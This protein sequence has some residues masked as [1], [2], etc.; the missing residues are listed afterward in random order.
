MSNDVYNNKQKSSL[1]EAY[2]KLREAQNIRNASVRNQQYDNVNGVALN[3]TPVSVNQQVQQQVQPQAQQQA[4]DASF[5][6]RLGGTVSQAA[7]NILR[8]FIKLGEGVVDA[9]IA[10]GGIFDKEWAEE[11]IKYDATD[12]IMTWAEE[13]ASA[14][15]LYKQKTGKSLYDQSW[16][17]DADEKV[18]DI[19][20]GIEQGIGNSLGF[21]ALSSIPYAGIGL[22]IMGAGGTSMEEAIN[23]PEY[24]GDYYKTWGYGAISGGIEYG[25]EKALGW[26]PS[27]GK[28]AVKSLKNALKDIGKNF[29][30]EGFEEVASEVINPLFKGMYNNKSL[31]ENYEDVTLENLATTFVIGGATGALMTGAG[32]VARTLYLSPE[33][34]K[35]ANEMQI[36]QEKLTNA[37]NEFKKNPNEAAATENFAKV[38]DEVGAKMQELGERIG[39]LADKYKNRLGS[40]Y[41]INGQK[42]KV[43]LSQELVNAEAKE[44]LSIDP[45][46][47]AVRETVDLINNAKIKGLENMNVE[48]V[49][50]SK[51]NGWIDRNTNTIYLN[52]N[53]QKAMKFILGHE[54]THPMENMTKDSAYRGVYDEIITSLK[55]NGTYDELFKTL[56]KRYSK[57]V[58]GKTKQQ[59]EE[60]INQ[61]IVAD[62]IG[63]NLTNFEEIQKLFTKQSTWEKFKDLIKN[64]RNKNTSS[65]AK[66]Y[67][68]RFLKAAA[69]TKIKEKKQLSKAIAYSLSNYDVEITLENPNKDSYIKAK[70]EF[71][72]T[73]RLDYAGW[74]NVDGS[75]LD[76]SDGQGYRVQD[77]REIQN[78]YKDSKWTDAL[79]QYLAE[80]NIRLQSYG[81]EVWRKPTSQQIEV[82]KR[83]IKNNYGE[84]VVDIDI[85]KNGDT[86][87]FEYER[88]TP[89][90][91]I[92]DD[93]I[94]YFDNGVEPKIDRQEEFRYS[95]AEEYS[96]QEDSEGEPLTK[97]QEEFFKN[98][99]IREDGNLLVL[100]HGTNNGGFMKFNS[101]SG[102][103]FF[104]PDY[105]IA[106]TYADEIEEHNIA[107]TKKFNSADELIDWLY[108]EGNENFNGTYDILP[109]SEAKEEVQEYVNSRIELMK[110]INAPQILLNN[111]KVENYK[112]IILD[113]NGNW[114]GVYA[115]E[116][117]LISNALDDIRL[118]DGFE[119]DN[120]MGE[121]TER[122]S[123][124][125]IYKVY[126]N[127]TNPLIINCRGSNFLE[128]PFRGKR[129]STDDIAVMVKEEGKYD[130]IIFK[131]IMDNGASD[132]FNSLGTSD[133]YVAFEPNQI[134]ATDN[135]NPTDYPDIRYSIGDNINRQPKSKL[136]AELKEGKVYN[137]NEGEVVVD[138]LE[139]MIGKEE[140]VSFKGSKENVLH[141]INDF[142][143]LQEYGTDE[144][145]QKLDK[146]ADQIVESIKVNKVSL[147]SLLGDIYKDAKIDLIDTIKEN[148]NEIAVEKGKT[149]YT[150]KVKK[151]LRNFATEIVRLK[152]L[153][154]K[155]T[156]SIYRL[157]REIWKARDFVKQGKV[158]KEGTLKELAQNV[159]KEISQ[160]R[161]TGTKNIEHEARNVLVNLREQLFE[162]EKV[163]AGDYLESETIVYLNTALKFMERRGAEFKDRK[164]KPSL[165]SIKDVGTMYPTEQQFDL[166]RGKTET[167]IAYDI[168]KIAKKLLKEANESTIVLNGQT[169]DY[170]KAATEEKNEQVRI[171]R[172]DQKSKKSFSTKVNQAMTS[173]L[174]P[175]A[176][177]DMLAKARVN[178]L[179][180][181]VYNELEAGEDEK[182]QI[183]M[184]LLKDL[185]TYIQSKDGKKLV[186][187]LKDKKYKI[188]L[189]GKDVNYGYMIGLYL[190]IETD[191]APS[192]IFGE[193]VDFVDENGTIQYI[194]GQDFIAMLSDDLKNEFKNIDNLKPEEKVDL[195]QRGIEELK[196]VFKEMIGTE[197]DELTRLVKKI[198]SST[199]QIYKSA[200]EEVLGYS[201]PQ[202]K[203]FYP[204]KAD[205]YSFQR[206]TGTLDDLTNHI[207]DTMNPSWTKR[208]VKNASNRIQIG[209]VLDT[210]YIFVD[211]LS[212]FKAISTR[213]K[214][215]DKLLNSKVDFE[216][217][218]ITFRQ[219]A[220]SNIDA[221]FTKRYNDLILS[222]QGIKYTP[223]TDVDRL[224][225]K[226]RGVNSVVALGANV[227]TILSQFT[228]FLKANLHVSAKNMLRVFGS[229]KGKNFT[230][231]DDI[232]Q[233]IPF[234][235]DRYYGNQGRNIA[236]MQNVGVVGN[237]S[238][239]GSLTM[240]PIE[241]ADYKTLALVWRA[242]QFECIN[243]NGVVDKEKAKELMVRVVRDTQATY[244]ALGNGSITRVNNEIIKGGLMYSSESRKTLTMFVHSVYRVLNTKRG[245][246]EN[247]KAWKDLATSSTSM[248][249]SS[250][251]IAALSF[252]LKALK[253]DYDEKDKEEIVKSL[254]LEELTPQFIGMIPYLKDIY[255]S[256]VLG[257]DIQIA[258]FSQITDLLDL[259]KFCGMLMDSNASGDDKKYAAYQIAQRIAHAFG[260]P[261][262]NIYNDI[263]YLA[264]I[265]DALLDTD[266]VLK[267]KNLYYNTTNSK[268][269]TL[270]KSY[271]KKEDTKKVSATIQIKFKKYGAGEISEK[272]ADEIA[273][274]YVNG[275]IDSMPSQLQ[276]TFNVNGVE[277]ELTK[278]Q[279]SHAKEVYSLANDLLIELMNSSIYNSLSDEEKAKA[280]K[281]LYSTYY[282]LAKSDV[283]ENYEVS[284]LTKLSDYI[285]TTK[286]VAALSK[287]NNIG[288]DKKST[289]KVAVM[290][291][292]NSLR[293]N[294]NEKYLLLYLSGYS[295][296]DSQEKMLLNFLRSKGL[297]YKDAKELLGI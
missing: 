242:V 243:E 156:P 129:M 215:V 181:Q 112:Y 274:L 76:F 85:N 197:S 111:E 165:D 69:N 234:L 214:K 166:L 52:T 73:Y 90:N 50:D 45:R 130:G 65:K 68:Q 149:S 59:A 108:E 139:F 226:A 100:Y 63:E 194:N 61:E 294:R 109:A 137:V 212:S 107:V 253:G 225:N 31:Q 87:T 235:Y 216:G 276:D 101:E 124:E 199:G 245:T 286:Y 57:L 94:N 204:I 33:G 179:F 83:H 183:K 211:Q 43:P 20:I 160:I 24:N 231:F 18:Q 74:L 244:T 135:Y 110:T 241:W 185:D 91:K 184:D 26:S 16:L 240:K 172:K 39:K 209:D 292:I 81:F 262:R 285:N 89:T 66:E 266:M 48:F 36:E 151:M 1:E 142:L 19:V 187:K 182:L 27:G 270:M 296:D 131:N 220:N 171:G 255:N 195:R 287:I 125:S 42:V 104:T 196:T 222:M 228:A 32:D 247:K 80:G 189:A 174:S 78:I 176:W 141:N 158:F 238:K 23:D 188:N 103:Y 178:S 161:F 246:L 56:N 297:S 30:E 153:N 267:M 218:K 5:F 219:F 261:M 82:L 290:R 71:G 98:S 208:T 173:L 233:E 191:N 221:N 251:L 223:T 186:S 265:G 217:S 205:P 102:V 289:R 272:A 6:E 169:I 164:N 122:K 77:H 260:I 12:A 86:K 116:E 147:K 7:N 284:K 22:S 10:I 133:V 40:V 269:T 119:Y 230:K 206:Q 203:V 236:E 4:S 227:K 97:K 54:I 148:I 13:N 157:F 207:S 279:Y 84:V 232:V 213:V 144:Y 128:V 259:P 114:V 252:F 53:S 258:G 105:E 264:G 154:A 60:Y 190:S 99:K 140:S 115:S 282:E 180:N 88:G 273:R 2:A 93:I 271:A 106:T 62:Y 152:K 92:I 51:N 49:T 200:S 249:A 254:L 28:T 275:S 210:V 239:L 237:A 67:Y 159:Y 134:K 11:T 55:E 37:Y 3:T 278:A 193:G 64:V 168:I 44:I 14:N 46:V 121:Y 248:I 283:I 34:S 192:H 120:F 146:L 229:S 202:K 132:L 257:Y 136:A 145:N 117:A 25:L 291:Y 162:N 118:E 256:I 198:Y 163:K 17:N 29:V 35:I 177:F 175:K 41:K 15:A 268:L 123:K 201:Y 295:I 150:S 263:M 224:L 72:T 58:K 293:M 167:D 155:A 70:K 250:C 21:A 95:I 170:K 288:E 138:E 126:V 8:S 38:R 277:V 280:I 47:R 143:N 127:V 281:K 96:D 113:E 79:I 9:H 75:M